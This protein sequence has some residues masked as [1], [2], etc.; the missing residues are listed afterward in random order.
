[1]GQNKIKIRINGLTERPSGFFCGGTIELKN[2]ARELRR[3][4]ER[5]RFEITSVV[6]AIL[7]QDRSKISHN[8]TRKE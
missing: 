5:L 3:P 1:M 4:H 2:L 7:P 6:I 8:R